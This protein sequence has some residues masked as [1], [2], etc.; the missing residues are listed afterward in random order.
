MIEQKL[1]DLVVSETYC[2][3]AFKKRVHCPCI[4]LNVKKETSFF[5]Y[6]S[7]TDET[8]AKETYSNITIIV[9]T[10]VVLGIICIAVAVIKRR[11]VNC[12]QRKGNISHT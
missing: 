9:P 7:S 5:Y 11:K 8:T 12:L 2:V 3:F 6:R 10:S 4:F 1:S